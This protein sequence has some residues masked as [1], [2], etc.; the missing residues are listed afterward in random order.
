[1]IVEDEPVIALDIEQRL[2]SLGYE[3][4][5]I[6]DSSESALQAANQTQPDLVLMD[7]NLSGGTNGITASAYLRDQLNLPIVFLTAHSDSNTFNKVKATSPFGYITKPFRTEDLNISIEIA[8]SRYQAEAAMQRA[9]V[10]QEELNRL[11]SQLASVLSHEFRN[12]LGVILVALGLLRRPS[13]QIT[14]EKQATY[15]DQ[16]TAAVERM[17]ALLEDFLIFGEAD[18]HQLRCRPSPINLCEFCTDLIEELRFTDRG[19]HNIQL[20]IHDRFSSRRTYHLDPKLLRHILTNLLMNAIKYSPRDSDI[21]FDLYSDTEDVTFCIRDHGIGIPAAD[22]AQLFNP[23]YRA[24]NVG[25]IKGTGLGLSIVK[26]CVLAHQ[27]NIVLD[28][29]AGVGTMFTVTLPC[30]SD[31]SGAE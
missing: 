7:V 31:Y 8:L 3:I 2:H 16:A 20:N 13:D 25:N 27:G 15:F 18:T 23:F 1:M 11:K 12:P 29:E 28:S 19:N 6:A 14:P 5:A 4:T 10:E 24:T 17:N 30:Q 21:H 9:L 26:Q 22:Q